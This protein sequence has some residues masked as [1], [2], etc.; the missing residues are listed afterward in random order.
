MDQDAGTSV[1]LGIKILHLAFH[2]GW[3]IRM[4]ELNLKVKRKLT[5]QILSGVY[6]G[7]ESKVSLKPAHPFNYMSLIISL[8][9]IFRS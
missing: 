8:P 2:S 7:L 9:S 6:S 3:K 5:F 1:N 4:E